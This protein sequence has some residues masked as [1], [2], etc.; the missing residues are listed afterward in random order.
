MLAPVRNPWLELPSRPPFVLEADRPFVAAFNRNA[1]LNTRLRTNLLPEPFMGRPRSASVLLLQL[2]PGFAGNEAHWHG[3][4]GFGGA[5]R[6]NLSHNGSGFPHLFLDPAWA[7]TPGGQWWQQRLRRVVEAVGNA[8]RVA[9]RLAVVEF[10]GYHARN[11]RSIPVTL[12]SQYYGFDLVRRAVARGAVIVVMRGFD[13][14][15]VAVP[16]LA[17][18]RLVF[19]PKNPQSAY[20]TE[21]A[22]GRTAFRAIVD[23][24]G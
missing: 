20:I 13:A 24:I 6:A 14:W 19:R 10:H 22:L 18:H 9:R 5:L 4:P 16:E 23:A 17:D 2:N 8:R 21:Q 7:G 15:T 3:R 12:P 11:Y 1:S